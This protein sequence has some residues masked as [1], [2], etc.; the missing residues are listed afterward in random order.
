MAESKRASS[1]L[2][3]YIHTTSTLH[4]HPLLSSTVHPLLNASQLQDLLIVGEQIPVGIVQVEDRLANKLASLVIELVGR[5]SQD[6][7]EDGDELG[8][9]LLDRGLAI[10]VCVLLVMF[11]LPLL[12]RGSNLQ[13]L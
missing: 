1:R 7:L 12:S 3:L 9:E 6:R 5:R 8:R 4:T 10:L 11:N 2:R 13:S